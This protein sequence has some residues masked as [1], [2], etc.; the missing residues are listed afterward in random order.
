VLDQRREIGE[1]LADAALLGQ[2]LTFAV[3]AMVMSENSK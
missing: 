1:V 2:T 3:A